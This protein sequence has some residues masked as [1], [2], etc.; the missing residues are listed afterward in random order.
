MSRI[1]IGLGALESGAVRLYSVYNTA[2][3]SLTVLAKD[4]ETATSIAWSA[5]HIR[6]TDN[7]LQG[8][9]RGVYEM[10]TLPPK[11]ALCEHQPALQK[12]IDERMQG[13]I[14]VVDGHLLVGDQLVEQ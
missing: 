10:R 2:H 7:G 8:E 11:S 14:E 4:I 1:R 3:Q 9:G 6:H 5:A 12:A 13:T